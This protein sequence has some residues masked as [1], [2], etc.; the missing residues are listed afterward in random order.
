[1]RSKSIRQTFTLKASPKEVYEAIIDE[2][3]HAEFSQSAAKI[4]SK[5]GG[6]FSAYD[7][8]NHGKIL[9]LIADEKIVIA[10]RHDEDDWPEDHFTTV[11]IQLRKIREGTR[12]NFTQTG[13]PVQHLGHLSQGWKD[14][15]WEPIKA[16]L[17]KQ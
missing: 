13:V 4:D 11:T 5:V 14:Y 17:E 12:L 3:K 1:M 16:M 2:K 9:E 6:A 8:Y 7:G 15:Y 10:L